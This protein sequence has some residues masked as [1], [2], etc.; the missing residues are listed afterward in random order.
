MTASTTSKSSASSLAAWKKAR[1][2]ECTCPSGT[3]VQ[4]RFPSMTDLIKRDAIPDH[5]RETALSDMARELAADMSGEESLP[6]LSTEDVVAIQELHEWLVTETVVEPKLTIDDLPE[7]PQE[8]LEMLTAIASR[9]RDIDARGIRLGVEPLSR[10]ES[11]R[12]FHECDA[13]CEACQSCRNAFSA[14]G[15]ELV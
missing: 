15:V 14:A 12:H 1:A 7:L 5:L 11:F 8:D 3:V 9:R 10:W 4:I 6:K 2:H 13:D